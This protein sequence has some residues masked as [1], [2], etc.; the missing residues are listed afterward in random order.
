[1]QK[2]L[3]DI[4]VTKTKLPPGEVQ[5]DIFDTVLPCF[6][7]R[8]GKRTRTYFVTYRIGGVRKRMT[9]GDAKRMSL[10]DAKRRGRSARFGREGDRPAGRAEIGQ[11]NV[12]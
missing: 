8:I 9:I 10:G 3:T 2:R 5:I 7:L 11:A 1:M 12:P 6:G 4:V